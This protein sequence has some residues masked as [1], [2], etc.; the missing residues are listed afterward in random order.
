[1]KDLELKHKENLK[2]QEMGGQKKE[3]SMENDIKKLLKEIAK[4]KKKLEGKKG[5]CL[6]KL[7]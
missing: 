7:A 6:T 3:K 2:T 5:V 1:M 4:L